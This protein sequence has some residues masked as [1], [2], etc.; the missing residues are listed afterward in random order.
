MADRFVVVNRGPGAHGHAPRFPSDRTGAF[1]PRTRLLGAEEFGLGPEDLFDGPLEQRLS[2]VDGKRL[3]GVEIEIESG[4]GLTEGA[5]ADDFSPAVGE[6]ADLRRIRGLTLGERHGQL[7]LE[8]AKKD[9]LEK[10]A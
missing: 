6:V 10:S 4:P 1:A 8:L 7:V 3:D 2:R 9:K 5:A